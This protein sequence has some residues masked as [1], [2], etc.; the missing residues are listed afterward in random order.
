M[1]NLITDLNGVSVIHLAEAWWIN[2]QDK[3]IVGPFKTNELAWR[4]L[5]RCERMFASDT[6]YYAIRR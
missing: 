6:P 2:A 5:D 4:W 3:L 1:T